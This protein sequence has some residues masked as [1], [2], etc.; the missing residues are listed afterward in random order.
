MRIET[1]RNG[2]ARYDILTLTPRGPYRE[3]RNF[4]EA[5]RSP[6]ARTKWLEARLAFLTKN[7]PEV[8]EVKAPTLDDF[9]PR[10][11]KEYAKANGNKPSTIAAKE[12]ILRLHLY[13][14]LGR[15]RLD[16]IGELQIQRLKKRKLY[17][18]DRISFIEDQLTPDIIA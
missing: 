14:S 16:E 5:L 4:P 12:T 6:S 11:M 15:L 17:L 9:G 13:P 8:E 1:P 2:K 7:G 18:R 10:W 3:R